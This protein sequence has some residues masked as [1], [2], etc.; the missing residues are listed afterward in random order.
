MKLLEKLGLS[1]RSEI[2]DL[3]QGHGLYHSDQCKYHN[4]TIGNQVFPDCKTHERVSYGF[5]C[6]CDFFTWIQIAIQQEKAGV[7]NDHPRGWMRRNI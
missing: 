2:K 5:N 3:A 6:C 4:R 7:Y 1:H